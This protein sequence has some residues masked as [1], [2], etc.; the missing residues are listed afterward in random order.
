MEAGMQ[1]EAVLRARAESLRWRIRLL[2]AQR[3][4]FLGLLAATLTCLGLVLLGRLQWMPTR[5]VWLPPILLAGAIGGA[6]L[7]L[8]RRVSLMDAARLADRRL[9]LKERLSSGVEFIG[10]GDGD[11]MMDAQIADAAEHATRL[12][13]AEAFPYRLPREAR[14]FG[15]ALAVLLGAVYLPELAVFQG[16]R[17]RAERE[18]MKREGAKIEA[19][20]KDPAR[21]R[22]QSNAEIERRVLQQMQALGRDM[23]RGQTTKKQA[24]L[25][26]E[27]LSKELK[28]AQQQLAVANSPK[29]LDRSSEQMKQAADASLKR[30]DQPTARSLDEMAKALQNRDLE[31]AATQ[32]KQL[33]EKLQSGKM[34]EA[35]IKA[36]AEALSQMAAAMK[37]SELDAAAK[38]LE[39]AA[40]PLKQL[41]QMPP[42]PE[43]SQALQQLLQ[44]AAQGCNAAGGT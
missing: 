36:A 37:G 27:R 26:M 32:L 16:P 39:Q 31:A 41:A 19:L 20:A 12:R 4:M 44:Q 11:A 30:G 23:K 29:S 33:A 42:G 38:Q 7:G 8:S 14:L 1:H 17:E 22:A 2:V 24:M 18:A 21:Q 40:Q 10:R 43:K 15:V 35:E 5:S 28:Q 25:R 3:W 34:S 6:G 9:D 13:A